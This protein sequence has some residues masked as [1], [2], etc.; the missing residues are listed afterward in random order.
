MSNEPNRAAM[1]TGLTNPGAGLKS[2]RP[3]VPLW[4]SRVRG[5]LRGIQRP[6]EKD[7]WPVL[8]RVPSFPTRHTETRA[9][10][11]ERCGAGD[12]EESSSSSPGLSD[13][14]PFMFHITENQ[15]PVITS[16]MNLQMP[17]MAH[18]WVTSSSRTSEPS[19]L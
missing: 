4:S 11:L 15:N 17:G 7:R 6:V 18:L 3:E 8:P 13:S 5:C 9:E 1:G 12:A 10:C 16:P 2:Q 14:S 19:S